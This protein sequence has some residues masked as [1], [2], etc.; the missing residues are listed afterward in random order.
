MQTRVCVLSKDK[1]LQGNLGSVLK[2]ISIN[3]TF[4]DHLDNPLAVQ[5]ALV[6]VD[7]AILEE[8]KSSMAVAK[9]SFYILTNRPESIGNQIAN[10]P[11]QGVL[12]K[13][14]YDQAELTEIVNKALSELPKAKIPEEVSLP[15]KVISST[16]APAAPA[17]PALSVKPVAK[18]GNAIAGVIF[19]PK[20]TIVAIVCAV[21]VVGAMV[22][23]IFTKVFNAYT[24]QPVATTV[25]ANADVIKTDL[26]TIK[27]GLDSYYLAN[28]TYPT[29]ASPQP[30]EI[31]LKSLT[32]NYLKS[33]PK[34][35]NGLT[36]YYSCV[37]GQN[38]FLSAN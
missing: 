7:D 13:D 34:N 24:E 18:A 5:D 20:A 3:P 16:Q 33:I 27:T 22:A 11:V 8:V 12:Y 4:Y 30:V 6:F 36:Y 14:A 37:D 23:L 28:Q 9:A 17:Q 31:A 35:V 2:S 1:N 32:G 25:G 10:L 19:S 21:V 15:V 29:V 38:Y 26:G